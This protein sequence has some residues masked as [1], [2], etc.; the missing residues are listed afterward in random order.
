MSKVSEEHA[1]TSRPGTA[2]PEK[3]QRLAWWAIALI[4][5][6]GVIIRFVNLEH[7]AYWI[8]EAYTLICASGHTCSSLRERYCDGHVFSAG[9][10]RTYMQVTREIDD[11]GV[12]AHLSED[13]KHCPLFFLLTRHWAQTFGSSDGSLRLLPA[14]ISL[15]IFPAIFWLCRELFQSSYTGGIAMALCA[16]SPL[17]FL[18][19]QEA[20]NYSLWTVI[21]IV[22]SA[23]LLR[24][25]RASR[26]KAWFAYTLIT[27][28]G[29][30]SYLLSVFVT[31]A[32]ALYVLAMRRKTAACL[33]S[34]AIA[35]LSFAPWLAIVSTN[36]DRTKRAWSWV[37][38]PVTLHEFVGTWCRN[39][40]LPFFD[41][42][43]GSHAPWQIVPNLLCTGLVAAAVI[44]LCRNTQKQVWLFVLL[45][46]TSTTLPL[47]AEDLL[48]G[49]RRVL[50]VRYLIPLWLGI[51][52]CVAFLL[53]SKT[54]SP[55]A[56][57]RKLWLCLAS[58]L[59]GAGL[60]SCIVCSQSSF[61]WNKHQGKEMSETANQLNQSHSA[62]LLAS[63]EWSK[64]A[65]SLIALAKMLTPDTKMAIISDKD[66]PEIPTGYKTIFL[67]HLPKNSIEKLRG[68]GNYTF[69]YHR[70]LK[71]VLWIAELKDAGRAVKN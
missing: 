43:A 19:A 36:W 25:M 3:T 21:I 9:E 30:Y 24:A 14:L 64:S 38:D 61:W 56:P 40:S 54:V 32:Q 57:R 60:V 26:M 53:A 39:L 48:S 15:L 12:I 16:V 69:K 59:I 29:F 45:L 66:A 46:M 63:N 33:I 8:D 1:I 31:G 42:N 41:V 34:I 17:H 55:A 50:M 71:D 23:V 6:T 52:L 13:A 11:T 27:S 70:D 58:A 22:S 67:Y 28:L 44:Y 20:R 18:W 10:L 51:Q 4:V 62:I 2:S 65:G 47:L 68:N 5:A 35:A 37:E 7:K 49:G